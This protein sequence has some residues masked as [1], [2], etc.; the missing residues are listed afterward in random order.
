MH[1]SLTGGL[2]AL[3]IPREGWIEINELFQDPAV[4]GKADDP[5]DIETVEIFENAMTGLSE[6]S[7]ECTAALDD[8]DYLVTTNR[9]HEK[10]QQCL[11]DLREEVGWVIPADKNIASTI[12][13]PV[14][15]EMLIEGMFPA[16]MQKLQQ[17]NAQSPKGEPSGPPSRNKTQMCALPRLSICSTS[18]MLSRTSLPHSTTTQP[19]T[20]QWSCERSTRTTVLKCKPCSTTWTTARV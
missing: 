2:S 4:G 16:F 15:A 3:H 11:V 13:I 20:P 7:V 17:T 9:Q 19:L 10:L 5:L 1:D 18:G 6:A 14:Q 12:E 8:V